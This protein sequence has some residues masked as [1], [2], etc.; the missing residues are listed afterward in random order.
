MMV[1]HMRRRTLLAAFTFVAASAAENSSDSYGDGMPDF[2]RLTSRSDQTAFRGWFVWLAR[3]LFE[4]QPDLPEE[5]SDC[6]GLLRFC[7][8]EALRT[9]HAEWAA[10]HRFRELPPL[11]DV[12][13]IRYPDPRF[14]AAVFRVRPGPYRP[15]DT[16]N[17]AFREFADAE[18]L[19]RYNCHRIGDPSAA[20]SGDLLFFKQLSPKE[21]F[22]SMIVDPPYAV[23]HTGSK[24]LRRPALMALQQHPEP[25]WRPVNGNSNFLGAYR[26]NILRDPS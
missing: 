5:V 8:H 3:T 6:S 9:H 4:R 21:P 13:K 18:H 22:H 14:G 1:N 23:Y 20:K 17:N 12:T 19:M 16:K 25:R 24:E 7:F 10:T 2:L 26:W 15:G 11:Q